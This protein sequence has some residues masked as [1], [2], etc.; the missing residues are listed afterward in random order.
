ME[1]LP[2][3]RV[4]DHLAPDLALRFLGVGNAQAQELGCAAAV[5]E[6]GNDPWL[7]IDCGP[8]IIA[9]YLGHYGTLPRALFITHVHFDHIGGLENL[10]YRLATATPAEPL[11]RLFVPAPLVALLHARLADY[12]NPL[13]EGGVNFWDVFQ[14]LPVGE[15]FWLRGHRFSV[16]QVRH[17]DDRS[18]FGLALAGA[19]LFSGDT[20]PIPEVLN[21]LASQGEW[22]FHDCASRRNPAHTGVEEL[23]VEYRAEQC[24][25]LVLYHYESI[26]VG[27]QLVQRGFR[28]VRRGERFALL[29]RPG[30]G[31]TAWR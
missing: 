24:A 6:Q 14:L 7:L 17:H 31:Q 5:L 13:A 27:E 1:Q 2:E 10:F 29:P 19:F 15:R 9:A 3:D 25:R 21:R 30:A 11:T 26:A 18:A 22:I 23:A 28:I 20:R 4:L 16:F 12:P 8:G